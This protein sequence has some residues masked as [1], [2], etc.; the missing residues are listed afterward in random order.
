MSG[1]LADDKD[2]LLFVD[3]FGSKTTGIVFFVTS[4]FSLLLLLVVV[5][6]RCC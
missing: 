2:E 3:D 5:E 1:D 6:D 4:L